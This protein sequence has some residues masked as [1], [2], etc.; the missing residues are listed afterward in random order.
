[1]NDTTYEDSMFI[2]STNIILV[3][4]FVL[5]HY[6]VYAY[7]HRFLYNNSNLSEREKTKKS[8][9]SDSFYFYSLCF[10]KKVTISLA[11]TMIG[12]PALQMAAISFAGKNSRIHKNLLCLLK[13]CATHGCDQSAISTRKIRR[14]SI[15]LIPHTKIKCVALNSITTKRRGQNA[16]PFFFTFKAMRN[17]LNCIFWIYL[18]KNIW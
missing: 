5:F 16:S 18:T 10:T 7:L 14:A 11:V 9:D 2:N 6:D 1:M 15:F 17:R 3:W 8:V 13:T 4:S 12:A